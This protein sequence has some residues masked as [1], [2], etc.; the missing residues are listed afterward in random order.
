[1]FG[2]RFAARREAPLGLWLAVSANA[3]VGGAL[4]GWSL[5]NVPVES[6]GVGGWL[7]SLAFAGVALLAPPVVERGGDARRA[8]AAVLA[9]A[10]AGG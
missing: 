2:A 7:R 4:I 9:A 3:T 8:A 1:M 6:L 5:A 10:R